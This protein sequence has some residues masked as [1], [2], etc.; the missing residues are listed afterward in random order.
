MDPEANLEEQL[1]IAERLYE[2]DDASTDD[3]DP[4]EIFRLAVRL[5]ELVF[6]LAK[7]NRNKIPP[8]ENRGTIQQDWPC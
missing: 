6:A 3:Q 4:E 5:A 2:I 8:E 1:S 7:W